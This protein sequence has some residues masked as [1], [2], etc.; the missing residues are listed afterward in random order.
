MSDINIDISMVKGMDFLIY[1]QRINEVIIW[2]DDFFYNEYWDKKT[3]RF[4]QRGEC[5]YA[6]NRE[7]GHVSFF[8]HSGSDRNE[9][10]F[11]GSEY[12]ITMLDGTKKV[13]RGPWSSRA[14]AMNM[15]GFGPCVDVSLRGGIPNYGLAGHV[16]LGFWLA[17]VKKFAIPQGYHVFKRDT[18]E[19]IWGLSAHPEVW[20]FD[21]S[22]V[23]A[24]D[25][26]KWIPWK[27]D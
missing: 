13:L 25:S 24:Y 18:L 5:F 6:E 23:P 3:L 15:K 4:A 7:T 9:G 22:G 27:V 21:P 20:T 1:N 8:A 17:C 26:K 14:G 19:P 16:T 11:G 12:E 10:G 2:K